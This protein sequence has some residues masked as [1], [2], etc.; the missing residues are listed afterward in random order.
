MFHSNLSM[1][2]QSILYIDMNYL[3]NNSL[4]GKSIITQLKNLNETNLKKFIE[5]EEGLQSEEKKLISQKNIISES[6]FQNNLAE[7]KSEIKNYNLKKNKMIED[8]NKLKLD[9]TNKLLKLINPILIKFS[10]DEKISIILQKK[11]LVVA[12][13]QLDI[14]EEVIKIIN[15]EVKEFKIK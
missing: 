2:N 11:N 12:K 10:N 7:L 5:I 3:L 14:T 4:A 15:S 6:N 9:N 8:F 1:A 13:T